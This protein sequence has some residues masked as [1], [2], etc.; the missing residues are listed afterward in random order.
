MNEHT[1]DDPA[2]PSDMTQAFVAR[3]SGETRAHQVDAAL[4]AL[5]RSTLVAQLAI[6]EL[7]AEAHRHRYWLRLR[8]SDG[9]LYRSAEHYFTEALSLDGLKRSAFYQRVRIGRAILAQ[10]MEDRNLVR[11]RLTHLGLSK[12]LALA[13]VLQRAPDTATCTAWFK[14]AAEMDVHTLRRAVSKDTRAKS[15]RGT[16]PGPVCPTCHRPY[17]RRR[18]LPV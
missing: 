11:A 9:S 13:P 8:R 10:P 7:A 4:R 5:G 18:Y 17:G 1:P 3:F 16:T 15:R 6:A 14:R 2:T 12:A